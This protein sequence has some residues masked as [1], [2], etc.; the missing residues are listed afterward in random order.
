M[1]I[2]FYIK[3]IIFSSEREFYLIKKLRF[4]KY[5]EQSMLSNTLELIRFSFIN[6]FKIHL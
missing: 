6:L 5:L 2:I 1:S 3:K 4:I